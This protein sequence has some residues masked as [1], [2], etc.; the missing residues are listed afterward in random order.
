MQLLFGL[1]PS[2]W[3]MTEQV[4]SGSAP[5]FG[6]GLAA[7]SC[8][9]PRTDKSRKALKEYIVGYKVGLDVE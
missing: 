5:P 8:A 9:R 6:T 1:V 3:V 4:G 2:P 7:A